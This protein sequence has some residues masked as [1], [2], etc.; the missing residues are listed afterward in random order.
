MVNLIKI[1]ESDINSGH[2]ME[3]TEGVKVDKRTQIIVPNGYN[4]VIFSNG[5]VIAKCASCPKKKLKKVIGSDIEGRTISV[6]YVNERPLTDMSWG[7]G[8]LT[9][10]YTVGKKSIEVQVGASGTFLAEICD[11]V[12]FYSTF[13]REFGVVTLPE[14]TGKMTEGIRAYA[15]EVLL[16]IFNDASEPII[17]TDF[18]LD[19]TDLRLN[20][21]LCDRKLFK[22]EGIIFRNVKTANIC[23]REEDID[24]LRE[25]YK[26]KKKK[27]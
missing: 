2:V 4:A 17:A 18:V 24:A 20:E 14:V 21:R 8:N 5:R 19:E 15:K 23:V 1:D 7:V 27:K 3:K 6:L 16:E 22:A 25:F 26:A 11:P 10:T 9:V 13:D 12:A